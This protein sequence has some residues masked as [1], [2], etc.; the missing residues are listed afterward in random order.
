[1]MILCD[2][3]NTTF[4]FKYKKEYFKISTAE[5]IDNFPLFEKKENIYFISVNK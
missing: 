3:G 4:H 2:I 5:T 1:M